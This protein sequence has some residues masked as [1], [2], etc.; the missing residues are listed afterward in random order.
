MRGKLSSSLISGRG[1]SPRWRSPSMQ[2]IR[3]ET[4]DNTRSLYLVLTYGSSDRETVTSPEQL[5]IKKTI[6]VSAQTVDLLFVRENDREFFDDSRRLILETVQQLSGIRGYS[7]VASA[8]TKVTSITRAGL[9]LAQTVT[10]PVLVYSIFIPC[11]RRKL[12]KFDSFVLSLR[13]Y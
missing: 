8:N 3:L 11:S 12:L 10:L 5:T 1:N 7:F 2:G 9:P 6:I 13:A 4:R